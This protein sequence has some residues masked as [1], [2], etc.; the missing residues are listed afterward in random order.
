MNEEFEHEC[1]MAD[2]WD[3]HDE[4]RTEPLDYINCNLDWDDGAYCEIRTD[5]DNRCYWASYATADLTDHYEHD[6]DNYDNIDDLLDFLGEVLDR[7]VK[8]A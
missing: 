7:E 5:I 3:D 8:I 4:P 2:T 6:T 1:M